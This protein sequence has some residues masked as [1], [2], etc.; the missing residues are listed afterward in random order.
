MI[1]PWQLLVI[2][3]LLFVI[4]GASRLGEVG[5]S[6]GEGARKWRESF[7]E[8]ES[9]RRRRNEPRHAEQGA[10]QAARRRERADDEDRTRQLR[11]V[12]AK[13]PAQDEERN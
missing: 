10:D 12:C 6:L 1:G 8:E 7:G 5:R 3:C 2:A 4:F 11:H 13:G 9:K